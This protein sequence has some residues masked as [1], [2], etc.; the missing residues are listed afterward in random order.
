MPSR[1]RR[2]G[3][4]VKFWPR[5]K[6]IDGRGNEQYHA[7]LE[8]KPIVTTA[9]EMQD[10][11]SRAEVPGQHEIDVVRLIVRYDLPNVGVWA[12]CYWRGEYWDVLTP[13]IYHY[14]TRQT[15]H[16]SML[17]KRRPTDDPVVFGV[18]S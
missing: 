8:A 2:R 6:I 4:E 17:I 9:A 10:R 5:E 13:P 18:E 12:I 1:Q 11:S 16:Q 14:G 7:N 15:R 3:R